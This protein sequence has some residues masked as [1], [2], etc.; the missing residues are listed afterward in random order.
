MKPI[1]EDPD[2]L[3]TCQTSRAC[4][5]LIAVFN[6]TGLTFS[7]IELEYCDILLLLPKMKNR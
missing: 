6:F 1:D 5:F 7:N 4:V 3:L 2:P